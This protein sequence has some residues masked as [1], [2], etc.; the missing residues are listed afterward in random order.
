M[1]THESIGLYTKKTKWI[2]TRTKNKASVDQSGHYSCLLN[3]HYHC[4]H[5]FNLGNVF[6]ILNTAH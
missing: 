5:F 3:L 4:A 2:Y 6:T 1:V